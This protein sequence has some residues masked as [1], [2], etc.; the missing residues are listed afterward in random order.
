[1]LE[2]IISS[3]ETHFKRLRLLYSSD[4]D[5]AWNSVNSLRIDVDFSF[6]KS[7][8]CHCGITQ[9]NTTLWLIKLPREIYFERYYTICYFKKWP[10]L[11]LMSILNGILLKVRHRTEQMNDPMSVRIMA[12]HFPLCVL[13]ELPVVPLW[14]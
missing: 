2:R 3:G 14:S 6:G 13:P 10:D 11:F 12:F 9:Y 4:S 5:E 1:M 7:L 8:F